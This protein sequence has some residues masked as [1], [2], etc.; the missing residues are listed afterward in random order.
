MEGSTSYRLFWVREKVNFCQVTTVCT[1]KKA[2]QMK[3]HLCMGS[4]HEGYLQD[5]ITKAQ[6]E[7]EQ[8]QNLIKKLWDCIVKAQ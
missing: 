4:T 2:Q 7:A 1:E 3:E 6:D 5:M 8:L